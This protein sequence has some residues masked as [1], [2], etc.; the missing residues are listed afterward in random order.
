MKNLEEILQ[1]AVRR[2]LTEAL[3]APRR[4]GAKRPPAPDAPDPASEPGRSI[5]KEPLTTLP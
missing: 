5:P 2:G 3:Q 1:D 4:S